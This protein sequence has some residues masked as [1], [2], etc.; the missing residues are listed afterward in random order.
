ML[1]RPHTA[2]GRDQRVEEI[3]NIKK[4]TII[5]NPSLRIEIIVQV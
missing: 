2:W 5:E 1:C 4:K 3:E